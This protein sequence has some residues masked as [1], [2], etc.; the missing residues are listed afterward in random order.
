MSEKPTVQEVPEVEAYET[1]IENH[2]GETDPFFGTGHFSIH[3]QPEDSDHDS[4]IGE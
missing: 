4:Y 2:D 1:P 3:H